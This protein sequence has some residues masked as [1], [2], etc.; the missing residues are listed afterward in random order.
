MPK[1]N[2]GRTRIAMSYLIRGRRSLKYKFPYMWVC[3]VVEVNCNGWQSDSQQEKNA[4]RLM[5]APVFLI[6]GEGTLSWTEND[7]SEQL[8]VV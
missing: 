6:C 2:Q 5:A 1:C 7:E 3:Y 4:C 8:S